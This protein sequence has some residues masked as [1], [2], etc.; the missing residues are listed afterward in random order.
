[1]SGVRS[2]IGYRVAGSCSGTAFSISVGNDEP[3]SIRRITFSVNPREPSQDRKPD[4]TQS[5]IGEELENAIDPA[6]HVKKKTEKVAG[7]AV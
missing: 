1:M 2:L 3:D 7:T 4:K 6:F 5:A